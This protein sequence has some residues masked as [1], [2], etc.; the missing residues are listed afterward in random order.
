[1]EEQRDY[2]TEKY[3]DFF[4]EV[5]ADNANYNHNEALGPYIDNEYSS[6]LSEESVHKLSE[7]LMNPMPPL[8]ND[9][10]E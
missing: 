7:D 6:G 1:M 8:D 3:Q 2:N 4:E 9:S 10:I 5:S